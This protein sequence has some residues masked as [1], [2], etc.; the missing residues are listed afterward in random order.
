MH[1]YAKYAQQIDTVA[2]MAQ[3]SKPSSGGKLQGARICPI[4]NAPSLRDLDPI[5][6][7]VAWGHESTPNGIS[8][9]SAVFTQVI[10]VLNTQR[11]M[12]HL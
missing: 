12:R 2:T 6:W 8:I 9:G 10:C 5:F 7:R 1:S 3:E 4:K 11:Y